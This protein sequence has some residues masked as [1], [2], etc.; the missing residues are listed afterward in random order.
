M[1]LAIVGSRDI[2]VAQVGL[3]TLIISGF[4]DANPEVM[5]SGGAVGIDKLAEELAFIK[6]IPTDIKLPVKKQWEPDGYR[7]RN[8]NIAKACTHLLS[9]RTSQ[10]ATYG[11][12]YTADRAESLGKVVIRV[13]L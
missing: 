6:K 8:D 10:S 3:A 2:T 7:I 13:E 1:K 12:G 11:S 5:I 4:L 9:I